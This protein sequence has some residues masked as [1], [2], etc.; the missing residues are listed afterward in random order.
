VR[1]ENG[2]ARFSYLKRYPWLAAGTLTCAILSTLMGRVIFDLRS[3]V[4]SHINCCHRAGLTIALLG[5]LMTRAQFSGR[6][7]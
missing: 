5:D 1:N 2:L 4:Y 3:D 7:P 6:N